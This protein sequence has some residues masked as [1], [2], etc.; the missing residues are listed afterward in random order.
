MRPLGPGLGL[1]LGLGLGPFHSNIEFHLHF[2]TQK[3][4]LENPTKRLDKGQCTS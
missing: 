3:K 4:L 1:G 2:F